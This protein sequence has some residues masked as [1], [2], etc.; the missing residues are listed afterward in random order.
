MFVFSYNKKKYGIDVK[1]VQI[2]PLIAR[3][4]TDWT[5]FALEWI[6]MG[7]GA[8]FSPNGPLNPFGL[9]LSVW[10]YSR[11]IYRVKETWNWRLK[12]VQI[13]SLIAEIWNGP[14]L[15]IFFIIF[16]YFLGGAGPSQAP[17]G[18][19]PTNPNAH[20]CQNSSQGVPSSYSKWENSGHFDCKRLHRPAPWLIGHF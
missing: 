3:I 7:P 9:T 15:F 11:S 10:K 20:L 14:F 2:G 12:F 13:G 18:L 5:I 4:M 17:Q 6:F 19:L 1:F 8:I 16:I